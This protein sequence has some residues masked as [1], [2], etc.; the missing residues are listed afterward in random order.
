VLGPRRQSQAVLIDED[1]LQAW[2]LVNPNVS[3]VITGASRPEQVVENM[4]AMDVL[5]KLTEE[6]LERIEGILDNKPGS[7]P[8]FR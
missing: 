4:A 2:C 3:T 7:E 1:R 8:D 6:V 5:P